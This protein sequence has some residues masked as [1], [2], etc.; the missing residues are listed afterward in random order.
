MQR[1]RRPGSRLGA[2]VKVGGPLLT[3]H[4]ESQGELA[5]ALSFAEVSEVLMTL[6]EEG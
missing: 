2:R 6:S 3:L 5:Y 1:Y 4:A